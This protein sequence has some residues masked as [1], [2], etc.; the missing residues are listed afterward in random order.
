MGGV[1][2]G[3][4]FQLTGELVTSAHWMTGSAGE[5]NVLLSAQGGTQDLSVFIE[6]SDASGWKS[7]TKVQIIVEM[8]E[9]TIKCET[10]DGW[11]RALSAKTIP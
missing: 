10:T 5:F 9:A 3:D 7:G 11:L 1:K 2:V 6:K 8:G 4:Q